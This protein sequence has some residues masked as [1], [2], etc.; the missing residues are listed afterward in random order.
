MRHNH[1]SILAQAIVYILTGTFLYTFTFP[2]TG[3]PYLLAQVFGG[4]FIAISFIMLASLFSN[5]L[6][7]LAERLDRIFLLGLFIASIPVLVA[8]IMSN[9]GKPLSYI[10]MV[11]FLILVAALIY[12]LI[13]Q[14][15]ELGKDMG[16]RKAATVTLLAL[17][18]IFSIISASA[19]LMNTIVF[20]NSNL[21]LAFA[22]VA[23]SAALLLEFQRRQ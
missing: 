17:S 23:I 16:H 8:D 21:W 7:S 10:L 12:R 22:V 9:I 11:W 1:I 13:R 20:L 19:M 4:I 2:K 5:R 14:Q 3:E 18:F 15:I 6:L